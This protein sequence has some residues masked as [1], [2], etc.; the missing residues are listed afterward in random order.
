MT[1]SEL[2]RNGS[3]GQIAA[4][5]EPP[6]SQRMAPRPGGNGRTLRKDPLDLYRKDSKLSKG[7]ASCCVT[8]GADY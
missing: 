7:G 4:A 3:G 1:R 2:S 8:G 6:R 5:A